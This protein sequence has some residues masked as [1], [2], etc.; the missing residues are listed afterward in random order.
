MSGS[1]SVA[2]TIRVTHTKNDGSN[3]GAR[4][5]DTTHIFQRCSLRPQKAWGIVAACERVLF[6]L[7]CEALLGRRLIRFRAF[8]IDHVQNLLLDPKYLR[9]AVRPLP[10][11]N[12]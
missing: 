5:I 6:A 11:R 1:I 7:A 12:K 9:L 2:R 10:L 8:P 4:T 3:Y